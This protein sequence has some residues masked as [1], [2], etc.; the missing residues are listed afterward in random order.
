MNKPFAFLLLG[1]LVPVSVLLGLHFRLRAW[2]EVLVPAYLCAKGWLLYRDVKFA[3]AP[4]FPGFLTSIAGT[5]GFS[6]ITLRAIGLLPLGIVLAELAW[7]GIR[8]GWSRLATGFA[9]LFQISVYFLWDCYAVYTDVWIAPLALPLYLLLSRSRSRDLVLGGLLCGVGIATKQP[10]MAVFFIA[11]VWVLIR[12]PGRVFHFA[13]PALAAPFLAIAFFAAF[14][15]VKDL[16]LWTMVMPLHF[17]RGR[18]TLLIGAAQLR[19]VLVGLIPLGV[20]VLW[21][22]RRLGSDEE[23]ILLALLAAGFAAL[24]IPRFE[25]VHLAAVTPFAA[26]AAGL[27]LDGSGAPAE[28]AAGRRL[29]L[30]PGGA[31]LLALLL[32]AA[33][34]A[35]DT[36]QGEITYWSSPADDRAV[37][38]LAR[39]PPGPLFLYGPDQNIFIRSGRV[40]PGGLYNN[41]DLWIHYLAED[42]ESRQIEILKN[43]PET[44]VL[45]SGTPQM[46]DGGRRLEQFLETNY[47]SSGSL[48]G[49]ST[50]LEPRS[51]APPRYL[52][53]ME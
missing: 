7:C 31:A 17:Y 32:S 15:A 6:P 46:G 28:T 27:A 23:P 20:V 38:E 34:L 45:K 8:K 30:L 35:T 41:P 16:T 40:P 42:L 1:V 48:F 21:R 5:V 47:L 22:R 2:P 52:R 18:S 33:Q 10:V 37:A 24:A 11:V 53:E 19:T 44:L 36:A 50:L 25:M 26:Y 43:H 9:M 13:L 29:H 39:F 14:G 4:V 3:H 51:A 49:G 12:T